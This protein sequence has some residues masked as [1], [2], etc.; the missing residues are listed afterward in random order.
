MEW[1]KGGW[2]RLTKRIVEGASF[3]YKYVML[4]NSGILHWW[5]KENNHRH[6]VFVPPMQSTPTPPRRRRRRGTG[7]LGRPP[8]ASAPALSPRGSPFV[9]PNAASAAAAGGPTEYRKHSAVSKLHTE[10]LSV[11]FNCRN[12]FVPFSKR[13]LVMFSCAIASDFC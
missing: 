11:F 12:R 8:T 6:E 1:S 10:E 13:L 7:G 2:W 9:S 4:D 3:E 5:E